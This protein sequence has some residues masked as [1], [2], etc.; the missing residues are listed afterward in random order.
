VAAQLAL[1]AST[2]R[3]QIISHVLCAMELQAAAEASPLALVMP[4]LILL[5][6]VSHVCAH[7]V[8]REQTF[9]CLERLLNYALCVTLVIMARSSL[10]V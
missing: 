5:M 2:R 7:K 6:A 10:G 1:L 4:V 8:T 3:R 9:M